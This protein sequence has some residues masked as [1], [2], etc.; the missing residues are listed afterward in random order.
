MGVYLILDTCVLLADLGWGVWLSGLPIVSVIGLVVSECVL[1]LEASCFQAYWLLQI[2]SS[3]DQL[4]TAIEDFQEFC[5]HH[6]CCCTFIAIEELSWSRLQIR[7][8]IFI[9]ELSWSRLQ[10]DSSFI[11]T[12]YC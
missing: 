4:L 11:W 7:C 2:S 10:S 9:E 12:S 5:Y 3:L 6:V 8:C 1:L